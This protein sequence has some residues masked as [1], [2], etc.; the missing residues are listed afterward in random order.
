MLKEIVVLCHFCFLR[1]GNWGT[2]SMPWLSRSHLLGYSNGC[3]AISQSEGLNCPLCPEGMFRMWKNYGCGCFLEVTYFTLDPNDSWLF[4]LKSEK[5]AS[6]AIFSRDEEDRAWKRSPATDD[7]VLVRLS[8]D[9][10]Q[11]LGLSVFIG[12]MKWKA[13][14]GLWIGQGLTR[15]IEASSISTEGIECRIF[16]QEMEALKQTELREETLWLAQAGSLFSLQVGGN[17]GDGVIPAQGPGS[18]CGSWNMGTSGMR[19][20]AMEGLPLEAKNKR[21]NALASPHL[22]SGPP[23]ASNPTGSQLGCAGKAE[24]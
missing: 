3:A 2:R 22:G 15:K 21:G 8:L 16:T 10:S 6:P 13:R 5:Q 19:A 7:Y 18:L 23:I 24:K 12:L 20:R 4:G 1:Y 17:R 14:V 11:L 9:A